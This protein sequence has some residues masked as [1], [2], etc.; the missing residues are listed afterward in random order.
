MGEGMGGRSLSTSTGE[1][2]SEGSGDGNGDTE[3]DGDGEA[4]DGW[5]QPPVGGSWIQVLAAGFEKAEGGGERSVV[6]RS[7]GRW[8]SDDSDRPAIR[9]LAD[10]LALRELVRGAEALLNVDGGRQVDASC[11]RDALGRG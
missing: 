7:F 2:S 5:A 4:R 3:V 10:S 9:V 8:A 6:A 1:G 11:G